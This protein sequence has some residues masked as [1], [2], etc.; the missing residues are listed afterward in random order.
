M[1]SRTQGAARPLT[2][3]AGKF[4]GRFSSELGIKLSGLHADD[5]FKWLLASVLFGARISQAVAK[6]TYAEFEKANVTSPGAVLRTGWDGL[7]DILDRGGYARYDFKTATKLLDMSRSLLD[8]YRGDLNE[9]HM[10]SA[11]SLELEARIKALAKGIG[12]VTANIFLREM[13]GLWRKAEPLPQELVLAAARDFGL[14]PR[15]LRGGKNVLEMLLQLWQEEGG[16]RTDFAD[17]ESALLR[18]GLLL[19]RRKAKS[20]GAGA[21]KRQLV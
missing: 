10:R 7:V 11:D 17:L 12:D 15:G 9:L 20:G 14:V 21:E 1:T 4:G 16:S 19:R 3:L 6:R 8:E 5:I 2:E 18:A 13:R